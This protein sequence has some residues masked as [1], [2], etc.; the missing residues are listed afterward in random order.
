MGAL[1]GNLCRASIWGEAANEFDDE[2]VNNWYSY[3]FISHI[4]STNPSTYL[5]RSGN[6]L[7]AIVFFDSYY[8]DDEESGCITCSYGLV[9]AATA[10]TS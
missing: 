2:Q 10:E 3:S 1:T 5:I 9:P 6:D 8:C 7:D 4:V